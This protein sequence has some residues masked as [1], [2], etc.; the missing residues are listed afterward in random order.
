[1]GKKKAVI[2]AAAASQKETK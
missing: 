1:M 2:K